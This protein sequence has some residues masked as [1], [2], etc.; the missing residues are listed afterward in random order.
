L[1]GDNDD[2]VPLEEN[3][4]LLAERYR[5]HGGDIEVVVVAEQGH[6]RDPH[7]FRSTAF[8]EFVI[9]HAKS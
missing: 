9:S 2:V 7:W 3:S 8:I 4:A 6:N 5:K 1:H